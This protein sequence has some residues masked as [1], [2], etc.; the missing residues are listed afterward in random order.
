MDRGIN[1]LVLYFQ[2]YKTIGCVVELRLCHRKREIPFKVSEMATQF[3]K[4]S[5]QDPLWCVNRG[6]EQKGLGITKRSKTSTPRLQ[7]PQPSWRMRSAFCTWISEGVWL[8]AVAALSGGR[9]PKWLDSHLQ[10]RV[11]AEVLWTPSFTAAVPLPICTL[12]DVSEVISTS[13][14]PFPTLPFLPG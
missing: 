14:L 5:S 11:I 10:T 12:C 7:C 9:P 13:F 6:Y 4:C 2:P 8:S 3:C 1:G